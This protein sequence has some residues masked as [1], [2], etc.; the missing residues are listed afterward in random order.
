MLLISSSLLPPE[1]LF[2]S[3]CF[4][5]LLTYL[6]VRVHLYAPIPGSL[7]KC[8]N[9]RG[10]SWSQETQNSTQASRVGGRNP[11]TWTM[12]Q[13]PRVHINKKQETGMEPYTELGQY[14]MAYKCLHCIL[15]AWPAQTLNNWIILPSQMVFKCLRAFEAN[16]ISSGEPLRLL[17]LSL[18]FYHPFSPDITTSPHTRTPWAPAYD[19]KLNPVS[20]T[21]QCSLVIWLVESFYSHSQYA[22]T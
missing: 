17:I 7:P 11:T 1:G 13:P 16:S 10:W 15:T 2:W 21:P 12:T 5:Y 18:T 19:F 8:H 6:R 9:A 3:M 14:D 4:I 20:P 22:L